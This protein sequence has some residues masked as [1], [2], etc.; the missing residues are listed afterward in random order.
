MRVASGCS[1]CPAAVVQLGRR[2][3]SADIGPSDEEGHAAG[4]LRDGLAPMSKRAQTRLKRAGGAN[5]AR[6]DVRGVS[7]ITTV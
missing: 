3:G 2:Q 1:E 5:R 6:F 4:W 7:I